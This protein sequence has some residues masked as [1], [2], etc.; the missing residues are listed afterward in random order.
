MSR[1]LLFPM[2]EMSAVGDARRE[3]A[4]LCDELGFDATEA[5]KVGIIVTEAG[6][7]LLKHAKH[8]QLILRRLS[9]PTRNGLEILAVDRG[10]GMADVAKCMTDGY[11]T[12]GSPGTGLGAIARLSSVFDVYSEPGKGTVLVSRLWQKRARGANPMQIGVVCVPMHATDPCGDSWSLYQFADSTR[13]LLVDGL[14]HGLLAARAADEA[15]RVFLERP[16]LGLVPLVQYMNGALRSTRGASLA[17]TEINHTTNLIRHCGAGNISGVISEQNSNRS[18]I[19]HNGTVGHELHSLHEFTYPWSPRALLIMH[20]DGLM[21]RW[22]LD[23]HPGLTVRHPS[24]IAGVL[25][26]DYQRGKDDVT[27]L[28]AR[29]RVT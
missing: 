9:D 14:G 24:V 19:S 25:Y 28:V 13:L 15:V 1:S 4:L 23:A 2:S 8:G 5:G 11:S 10:P 20:S 22:R 16:N 18:M 26:R 7:N 3:A 12:A 27:V 21:S 29:Q 6:K 17:I